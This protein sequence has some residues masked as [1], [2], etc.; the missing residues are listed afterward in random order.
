MKTVKINQ[1]D[2]CDKTSF[3]KST[4]I[5][6]EKKCF[7]NPA[8]QSCATCLWFSRVHSLGDESTCY[9]SKLSKAP[10]GEK[11]KLKTS[12]GNWKNADLV[13]DLDLF[14]NNN[15]VLNRLIAG[16][17]DFFNNLEKENGL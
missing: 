17:T 11:Q 8:T 10:E 5:Q 16:D 14:D 2:F 3:S 9:L 7:F 13:G 15:Q 12:C 6:H 4:I 1:C